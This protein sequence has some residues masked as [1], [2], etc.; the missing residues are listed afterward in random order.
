M[1]EILINRAR[2]CAVTG[3]RYLR[4]NFNIEK[5]EDKLKELVEKGF[6]TFLI[7]M[8]I[9]F[10][11]ICFQILE[12]IREQKKL[13]I[14]ACIP[15]EEQAEKFNANQKEEYE[16][17]LSIA[18][19]KILISKNYTATCMQKRNQFM[20]D[21]SSAVLAYLNRDF[22]GTFNTV[23]YAQKKGIPVLMV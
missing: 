6:D 14:I 9:G 12:K 2:T 18:D 3:H 10:D 1:S 7:G 23:K 13:Y 5:V 11:M 22:G 4:K 21:N 16:R 19:Q 17:L 8:A 20:V 15:C